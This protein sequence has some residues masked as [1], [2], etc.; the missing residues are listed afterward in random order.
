MDNWKDRSKGVKCGTCM[1]SISKGDPKD[2]KIGRCRKHAPT[3]N[4]WPAI[5]PTDW[6]GDHKI[7]ENKLPLV[8]EE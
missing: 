1:W 7:D 2:A 5:F 4:G 3:L 8:E 6:C